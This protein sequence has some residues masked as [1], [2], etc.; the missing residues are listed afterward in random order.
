MKIILWNLRKGLVELFPTNKFRFILVLLILI[1]SFI[2]VSELLVAKLFAQIILHEGEL[3]TSKLKVYIVAFFIFYGLTR[4]GHFWHKIYRIRLIDKA[5]SA[6]EI[7]IRKSKENWRWS[8]AFQLTAISSSLTQIFVINGF[9]IYFNWIFG[10]VNLAIILIVLQ[11]VGGIFKSQLKLQRRFAS[12]KKKK[13]KIASLERVSTRIKSGEI[14]VLITGAAIIILLGVLFYLNYTGDIS[15]G[16]TIVLFFGLRMQ[17]SNLSRI[18]K[19][20]MKFARART[21]SEK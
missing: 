2:S 6:A 18:S 19:G 7:K 5:F 8:L 17:N 14:G 1:A 4:L 9:F 15:A 16:N 3:E 11:I 10:L 13:R 21:H 20:L 12:A